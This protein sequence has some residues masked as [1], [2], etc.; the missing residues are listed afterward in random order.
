VVKLFVAITDRSWF[1]RLSQEKPE[2]VNFWQPSGQRNF[3][4]LAPGELLLFK[5]HAPANFIVG[6]GVFS[7]A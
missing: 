1:D 2:E 6:G 4:A 5:L 7:H 3:R